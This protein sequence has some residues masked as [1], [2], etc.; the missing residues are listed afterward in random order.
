MKVYV[1]YKMYYGEISRDMGDSE[2]V[3]VFQNIDEVLENING[4]I[5]DK[6]I[7]NGFYL[8][9]Q[10]NGMKDDSYGCWRMFYGS[11]ENWNNYYEIIVEKTNLNQKIRKGF[12]NKYESILILNP[13]ISDNIIEAIRCDILSNIGTIN[14]LKF[15]DMGVKRLAYDTKGCNEG[16]YIKIEFLGDTKDVK[17]LEKYFNDVCDIIKY[18]TMKIQEKDIMYEKSLYDIMDIYTE[19]TWEEYPLDGDEV[20]DLINILRTKL[21]F[22]NGNITNKEYLES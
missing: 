13:K 2:I 12:L 10:D 7:E 22:I 18:L 3:G 4:E 9:I 6:D 5:I 17:N 8:D 14:L 11:E 15:D 21:N 19:N 20:D 16:H 1:V